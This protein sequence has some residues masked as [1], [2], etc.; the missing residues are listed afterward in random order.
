MAGRLPIAGPGTLAL[1]A[2]V[3]AV[4]LAPSAGAAPPQGAVAATS[5]A[6]QQA[7]GSVTTVTGGVTDAVERTASQ[8]T[9]PVTGAVAET[10]TRATEAITNTAKETVS[11]T[12]R[13]VQPAADKVAGTV[14][15]VTSEAT[16]QAPDRVAATVASS[17]IR[18]EPAAPPVAAPRTSEPAAG[19]DPQHR[20]G[21]VV[22]VRP[23]RP[24]LQTA[25]AP[26]RGEG[27][28]PAEAAGPGA[29]IP[30]AAPSAPRPTG[31]HLPALERADDSS[32]GASYPDLAAAASGSA[33]ALSTG[34]ALGSL[35]LLALALCLTAPGLLRRLPAVPVARWPVPLRDA[36]ERPG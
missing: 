19:R 4:L 31:E 14:G 30:P 26:P 5:D 17:T 7:V 15:R 6:V 18:G 23:D 24:N 16:R 21:A 12:T 10:T 34:L 22:E 13:E 35:A 1:S 20:S 29:A 3:S 28:L 8:V 36:L 2:L 9:P 33:S 11:R 27:R 32:S 25:G